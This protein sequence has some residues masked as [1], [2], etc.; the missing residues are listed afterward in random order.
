MRNAISKGFLLAKWLTAPWYS[1]VKLMRGMTTLS[2]RSLTTKSRASAEMRRRSSDR[3][4]APTGLR[5]L[6]G[7]ST[8]R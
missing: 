1:V 3:P 8:G 5:T 7:F 4:P 6:A 2:A